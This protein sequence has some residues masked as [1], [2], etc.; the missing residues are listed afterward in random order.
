MFQFSA[1]NDSC[2]AVSV[3]GRASY[4]FNAG[5]NFDYIIVISD[6]IVS[7][8]SSGSNIFKATGKAEILNM[9]LLI[10]RT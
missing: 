3:E 5:R 4:I 1:Y 7:F 8:K 6:N 2:G 9:D 10:K